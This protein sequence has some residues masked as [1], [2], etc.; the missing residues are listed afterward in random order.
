LLEVVVALSRAPTKTGYQEGGKMMRVLN[1]WAIVLAVMIS[2]GCALD[3]VERDGEPEASIDIDEDVSEVAELVVVAEE[4]VKQGKMSTPTPL[5]NCTGPLCSEIQ[6]RSGLGVF[7]A[8]NWCDCCGACPS[9]N[10]FRWLGSPADTPDSEDWDTFRVDA[11]W[12]YKFR[13]YG[14]DGVIFKTHTIDRRGLGAVWVKV[15]DV[16]TARV[17]FQSSSSCG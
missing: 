12:C 11:G 17:T 8:R 9:G 2:S 7:I 16:Q 13:M 5:G 10:E 15:L 3:D 4:E 1:L 6:N 14:P